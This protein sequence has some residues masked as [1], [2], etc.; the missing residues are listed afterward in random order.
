MAGVRLRTKFLLSFLLSS[1]GLTCASLLVVRHGVE[2]QVREEISGDLRNSVVT[3]RSVQ[4]QREIALA[5]SA[6]LL[7][8]MPTLKALMTTGDALTIQ[9]ASRDIWRL[10]GSGLFVLA[11]RETRVVALHTSRPGFTPVLA[12]AALEES[13]G[14]QGNDHWWFGGGHLYEVFVQPIYFGAPGKS[15]TLGL[16]AVG[17]EIDEQVVNEISRI[18]ASQVAFLYGDQIAFST[19][20]DRQESELLNQWPRKR[21]SAAQ[22]DI[23]LGNEEFLSTSVELSPDPSSRA[24]VRLIVLK[25]YDQATLFLQRLNHLLIVLGL[26]TVLIGGAVVSVISATFT[27][28]LK[29]LVAGVRS[30]ERGDYGY[31]LPVHGNDEVAEVTGAFDRMRQTVRRTQEQLLH[32]ERL[33]TI[34][35]MASSISHDLR[36]ALTAMLANAEFLCDARLNGRRREDL[37]QEIR[38]AVDHMTDLL[39]SLLEFSRTRE[40]LNPVLGNIE[41]VI[42]RAA[43]TVKTHPGFHDV[44]IVIAGDGPGICWIDP[45]KMERVFYNLLLNAC[46]AVPPG[47]GL[48][49]VTVTTATPD[50]LIVRIADNGH[51]I[52]PQIQEKLFHP[53]TSFGKENGSGLGLAVVQKIVHDHGGEISVESTSAHGAVFKL[54]LPMG[55]P[56]SIQSDIAEHEMSVPPEA[57]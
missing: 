47:R 10:S 26:A 51:G 44:R 8:S 42:R 36:H 15:T 29:N 25:S 6:E 35:T 46:D 21:G 28:P 13:L 57:A 34:G 45:R 50:R 30:L 56:T 3:F 43:E 20:S 48:V 38:V 40:S 23:E 9:D 53:F 33:A 16:L 41:T 5:R 32:A 22:S 11:N 2:K 17:Y 55:P 39:E 24:P 19:L 12:Q 7:A 49:Q 37:Y 27:R 18:A 52:A 14:D 54:V 1:L 4:R 31:P